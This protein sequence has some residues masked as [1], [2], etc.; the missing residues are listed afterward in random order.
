M[1]PDPMI[2]DGLV[3]S[4]CGAAVKH[5]AIPPVDLC[6]KCG[7]VCAKI[8]DEN[9]FTSKQH[10]VDKVYEFVSALQ[11]RAVDAHNVLQGIIDSLE[12]YKV[13]LEKILTDLD[14]NSQPSV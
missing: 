10:D 3:S 11:D 4:C 2:L 7:Y 6:S 5:Y 8:A 12:E 13:E 1:N 9:Q 14:N